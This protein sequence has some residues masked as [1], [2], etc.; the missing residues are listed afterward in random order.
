M[1]GKLAPVEDTYR[2]QVIR[3]KRPNVFTALKRR[4]IIPL[5][6]ISMQVADR[7]V[8]KFMI[9]FVGEG[10]ESRKG[11]LFTMHLLNRELHKLGGNAIALKFW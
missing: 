5:N 1:P 6:M 10:K 8:T 3:V 9:I 4:Q 2:M 11:M 7:T